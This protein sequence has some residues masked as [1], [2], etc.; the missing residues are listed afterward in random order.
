MDEGVPIPRH[1]PGLEERVTGVRG[2]PAAEVEHQGPRAKHGEARTCR[3]DHQ[4]LQ[5]GESLRGPS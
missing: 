5:Q 4:Q 2:D 1:L 3:H